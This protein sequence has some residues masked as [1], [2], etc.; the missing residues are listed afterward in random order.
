MNV[1]AKLTVV[2]ETITSGTIKLVVDVG[3]FPIY[4]NAF[5]LCD[6]ISNAGLTCPL[7]CNLFM[8]PK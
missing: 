2:G 3:N 7:V 8:F 1:T 4:E 5:S 6:E